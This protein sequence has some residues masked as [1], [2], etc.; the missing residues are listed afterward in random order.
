MTG[1]FSRLL[2]AGIVSEC[3]LLA[4]A[5]GIG[6]LAGVAPFA[7]SRPALDALGYGVA[8][9]LPL[10]GL[11]RWCLR[12]TWPPMRR[13][14]ALVEEQV[15]PYVTGAPAGGIVLLSLMAGIGEEALFRGVIQAGLAER[16]PA[17]VAVG[18][19]ALLF[20]LGHWVSRSYALLAGVI[21]AYL[22]LL[23]LLTGNL[24]AP[25]IT[26]ALYDVAALSVLARRVRP[27]A[28]GSIL[29]PG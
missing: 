26:H 17:P 11:L 20:G 22:G 29:P 21:G 19:A 14:V 10:L 7:R 23:F 25:I 8:A 6:W 15:G 16:L 24:L 27:A 2:A 28:S 4:A 9:T 3:A 1:S 12:T 18:I 5:F 13:L